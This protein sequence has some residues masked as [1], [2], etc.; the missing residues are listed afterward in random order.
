MIKMPNRNL[1]RAS[2]A[3]V[4]LLA[5]AGPVS[6]QQPSRAAALTKLQRGL[7]Q[8][9]DVEADSVRRQPVCLGSPKLL[10]Q[11]EHRGKPCSH[12]VVSQDERSATVHYTC[13]ASDFGQTSL[14]LETPRLAQI[15]T[16][17]ISGGT[18]FSYRLEAR[19][20]G[21]CPANN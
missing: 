10:L 14:K 12:L 6:S 13:P 9:R 18:P 11:L 3:A 4:A 19:R 1:Y 5:L 2:F 21:A 7:W 17:G 15:E 8:L 20:V 16:Q